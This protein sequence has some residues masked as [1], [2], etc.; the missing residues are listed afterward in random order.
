VVVGKL[1]GFHGWSAAIVVVVAA[2]AVGGLLVDL[3]CRVERGRGVSLEAEM[4]PPL[5]RVI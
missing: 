1:R 2:V 3:L 5:L 4:V